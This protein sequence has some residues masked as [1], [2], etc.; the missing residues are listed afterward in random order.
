MRK[1][2]TFVEMAVSASTYLEV[3]KKLEDADYR[4][5][6]LEDGSLDMHGIALVPELPEY[7][8]DPKTALARGRA[9][10]RKWFPNG[11]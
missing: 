7:L 11:R 1:T 6:I 10:F 3:L 9:L 8:Q 5:A 2:H 4:H